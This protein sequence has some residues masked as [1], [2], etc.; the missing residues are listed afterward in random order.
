MAGKNLSAWRTPATHAAPLIEQE[1]DSLRVLRF[2]RDKYIARSRWLFVLGHD[3]AAWWYRSAAASIN[4]LIGDPDE[5]V[6]VSFTV[7][8]AGEPASVDKAEVILSDVD[9]FPII[10]G[11]P[12]DI[13]A[14][15]HGA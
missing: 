4:T 15:V 2:V 8:P 12:A 13:L 6:E 11:A 1:G 7:F 10:G 9:D 14:D 5:T 3:T